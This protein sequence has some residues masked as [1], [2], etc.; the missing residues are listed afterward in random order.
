MNEQVHRNLRAVRGEASAILAN[1]EQVR[2]PEM[3][4][5]VHAEILRQ[6]LL[7]VI[8][9]VIEQTE[10]VDED[11]SKIF[12]IC[13]DT[14]ARMLEV[15]A[16]GFFVEADILRESVDIARRVSTSIDALASEAVN[17]GKDGRPFGEG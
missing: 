15:M 10:L 4:G 6:T 11:C 14:S 13:V 16:K 17:H 3:R 12:E 5:L 7:T 8:H 1:I 9:T 2:G